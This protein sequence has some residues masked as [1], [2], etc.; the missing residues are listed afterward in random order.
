MIVIYNHNMFIVE[1]TIYNHNMFIVE[2]TGC[3]TQ[4]INPIF[5]SFRSSK[6]FLNQQGVNV[7]TLFSYYWP[8]KRVS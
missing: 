2:A 1:A 8:S 6:S 3:M 5:F 4:I 7:I